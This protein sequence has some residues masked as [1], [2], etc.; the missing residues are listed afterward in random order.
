VG[1][2]E[3]PMRRTPLIRALIVAVLLAVGLAFGNQGT[4]GNQTGPGI[5]DRLGNLNGLCRL[6]GGNPPPATATD[7][8]KSRFYCQGGFLDGLYCD[9]YADLTYCYWGS[10]GGKP[11]TA[12]SQ[13]EAVTNVPDL[14]FV[15]EL[16]AAVDNPIV[17]GADGQPMLVEAIITWNP[18]GEAA[19][20]SGLI[21]VNACRHLGG[22]ERVQRPDGDPESATFTI[23]C[24]DGLLDGMWCSM[25]T[26]LNTCF[27]E[28]AAEEATTADTPAPMPTEMQEAPDATPPQSPTEV[29]TP[30]PTVP[31]TDEP[32]IEPTFVDPTAPDDPWSL[33]EG[34]L[35]VLEPVEPT[36]VPLT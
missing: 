32:V 27:F 19:T 26:G 12:G 22:A 17:P 8:V 34:T 18:S 6:N 29:P 30:T 11:M 21:Q 2:K 16:P 3:H 7:T 36:D 10:V 14:T 15:S 4:V 1:E 31:P 24:Q 25:G 20:A 23:L 28:P 9:V 35:P 5:N 33:P 13:V